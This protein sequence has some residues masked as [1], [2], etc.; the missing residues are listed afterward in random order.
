MGQFV[1]SET[2]EYDSSQSLVKVQN[3]RLI[4]ALILAGILAGIHARSVKKVGQYVLEDGHEYVYDTYTIRTAGTMD[5]KTHSA[6]EAFQKLE[7]RKKAI[8]L[9]LSFWM[10][11]SLC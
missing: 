11:K 6:G 2:S 5:V 4:T 9:M 7:F 8:L 1:V 3:M 10:P